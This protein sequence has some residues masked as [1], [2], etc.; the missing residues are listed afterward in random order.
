M[1]SASTGTMGS[2]SAND[3]SST[4]AAASSTSTGE[5]PPPADLPSSMQW[6]FNML[7]YNVAGLPDWISDGDPATNIPMMS[8]L[9]NNYDLVLVQ[10][11]FSYH[12]DL[13]K[14]ATHPYQSE[15][16]PAEGLTDLGD[17]LNRFS[18]FPFTEFERHTW[19]ECSG[20]FDMKSDCLTSKGFSVGLHEF[21]PGV[22]VDVY[23]LHMD[24]G[25]APDDVAA[26]QAQI[27]QILGT[28]TSRSEGRAII[29]VGDTNMDEEDEADFQ[30]LLAGAGLTD[31][32]RALNCPEPYRID[33]AMFRSSPDVEIVPEMWGLDDAFVTPGGEPLSDHEA[34]A[35]IFRLV[36][37]PP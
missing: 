21:A 12:D 17:G 7:V 11:D 24:A 36:V 22:F 13:A 37:P 26:R 23:N 34:L 15:P 9:L 18:V 4:S 6:Q 16:K 32:C 31:A 33:R 27:A 25:S 20:Y 8:P 30:T 35:V 29:V 5:P 10:E 1:G 14:D 19:N 3:M 2:D 28:I